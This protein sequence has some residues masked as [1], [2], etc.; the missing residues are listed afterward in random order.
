MLAE[1]SYDAGDI[2][3]VVARTGVGAL[4]R[5]FELP[6]E[7]SGVTMTIGGASVGLQYVSR[8]TIRFVVPRGLSSALT[9]T[10]YPVVVNNNGLVYKGS[11][12]IVP[13]RPDLLTNLPTP[14]PGGRAQALNTT[15]RIFTREPFTTSTFRFKGS[16]KVGT[17]LRIYMTGIESVNAASYGVRIGGVL[18]SGAAFGTDAVR[19]APGIYYIELVI[20]N[21]IAGLPNAPI[22]MIIAGGNQT[23][24]SRLEDTAPVISIL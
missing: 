13:A 2:Q 11:V 14:G 23:F 21:D 4:T 10:S 6:M 12:I 9:G 22:V 24:Y 1:L 19:V 7:L 20:G 18:Y 17:K 15:T 16:R 3:P 5:S 8:R